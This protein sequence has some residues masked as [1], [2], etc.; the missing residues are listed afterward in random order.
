MRLPRFFENQS[1][2]PNTEITLSD[3]VVQHVSRA[4]RMRSGD[5][6]QL[7]NQLGEQY[8]AELTAV[9]K[10]SA[11]ARLLHAQPAPTESPLQV[12]IGQSLSRGERMDYAVQKSTEMGVTSITPLFSSR[13]EVKL[14]SD[15]QQK[16]VQHWQQIA[17]SACEQSGRV[18]PPAINLPKTLENWLQQQDA[19]LKL[20]LHHHSQQPLAE[21]TAPTS[22]ALLI[23]P[24]GGLTADEVELAQSYGFKALTLGPRVM[25]TETAPVAALTLMNYLWG[26]LN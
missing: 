9:E 1:F 5:Q 4:L 23:G 16:R 10:R 13:C 12:S 15:R 6:L 25:R 22:V 3:D 2:A 19:E 26:D 21:M 14:P 17:I 20:V 11:T 18:K 8:L 7:F 24:E